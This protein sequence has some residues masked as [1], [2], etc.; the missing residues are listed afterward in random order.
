MGDVVRGRILPLFMRFVNSRGIRAVKDGMMFVMPLIIVGA[1]YLLLETF[2]I[3]AIDT[4]IE[5]LGI[6][7]FLRHGYSSTFNIMALVAAAS[8]GYIWAKNDGFEPLTAGVLS[9]AVFLILIPD[10]VPLPNLF[11]ADGTTLIYGTVS[12]PATGEMTKQ[13]TDSLWSARVLGDNPVEPTLITAVDGLDKTWL[14]GQGMIGAIIAGLCTGWIYTGCLRKNMTIKMPEGV[15]DGVAAAFTGLIPAAFIFTGAL[16]IYGCSII[17]FGVTPIELIYEFVQKPLQRAGGSLPGIIIFETLIPL[18]WFCGVHGAAVV[19]S[20]AQ[21]IALANQSENLAIFNS[22][23]ET[24]HLSKEEAI[25]QLGSHGA[26][27]FTEAFQNMFQAP[28]GSGITLG[29]VIFMVFFAKSTR[30]RQ[31]GRLGLGCGIFNI[32]EPALFGTPIVFNLKLLIPFIVAP[33]FCNVGAYVLTKVGFI[34]YTYGFTLPWT[35]PP[36]ISGLLCAGP[37]AALWQAVS[38]VASFFIYLPFAR[39]LDREYLAAEQR[40]DA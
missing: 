35:T 26:H 30:M 17:I 34:P 39:S 14:A 16:F 32:N 2:P 5:N 20:V 18:F 1:V 8:V 40:E 11:Q 7:P 24:Q 31:V 4:L 21:P 15:P 37:T 27:V 22:L 23:M 36:I 33:L 28:G 38:L 29:L 9:L 13:I 3:P 25:A 19:N 6:K 10:F 12:D